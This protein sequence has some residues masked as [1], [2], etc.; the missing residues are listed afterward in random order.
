MR[1]LSILFVAVLGLPALDA[2]G[3]TNRPSGTIVS[4]GYQNIPYVEPGLST[5]STTNLMK[6]YRV[7]AE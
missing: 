6:F 3:Q 1:F 5:T 2:H 4:W 7:K